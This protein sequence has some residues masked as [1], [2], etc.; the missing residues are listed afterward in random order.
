MSQ[1]T[2]QTIKKDNYSIHLIDTKKFK[3]NTIALKF[4]RPLKRENITERALLPFVLQKGTE[5]YPTE[6]A[7]RQQLDELYGA[8][9]SIYGAKKGENHI[10]TFVLDIPNEKFIKDEE[11]LTKEG[12]QFLSDVLTSPRLKIRR[13]MKHWL[14][15]KKTH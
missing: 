9:F 10:V 12:L 3:T 14:R 1:V 15:K 11:T 13:S 2:E 5:K 8:K 7:L 6:R 4:T